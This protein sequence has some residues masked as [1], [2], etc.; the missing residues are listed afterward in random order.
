MDIRTHLVEA[1]KTKEE[2]GSGIAEAFWEWN[3]K[4]VQSYL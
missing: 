3:E 2:G 1:T 4:Q